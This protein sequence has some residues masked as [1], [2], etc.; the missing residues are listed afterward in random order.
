MRNPTADPTNILPLS[1]RNSPG[2]SISSSP[3]KKNKKNT[4]IDMKRSISSIGSTSAN[5]AG[6]TIIPARTFPMMV[7]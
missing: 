2:K 5:N 7:G 4:P 6:P 1:T 3:I